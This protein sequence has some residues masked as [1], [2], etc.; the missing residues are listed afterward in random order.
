MS[1][2]AATAQSRRSE[3]LR[4]LL[5]VALNLAGAQHDA[6]SA[7][8]ADALM[9][10]SETSTDSREANLSF[11]VSNLLKNNSY[12]FQHL[13]AAFLKE[14][15]QRE[16]G[17]LE[18]GSYPAAAKTDGALSLVSYEEMDNKLQIGAGSR[19][20]EQQHADAYHALNIRLA[21]LLQRDELSLSQNPFRPEVF[22][23][24]INLAWR[25]FDPDPES[26]HLVMPLLR[27]DVFLQLSP[28]LQALNDALIADGILPDLQESYRIKKTDGHS[29]ATRKDD[30]AETA[31]LQKN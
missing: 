8:L 30:S 9:Q 3:I 16:L 25:N 27:P 29:D 15:L 14:N 19:P 7:R 18:R 2:N 4:D 23:S 13:A 1:A 31:L 6:F 22:L 20:F 21:N 10:Q 11:N 17:M 24:A 12:A 28:L 5:P 26:H